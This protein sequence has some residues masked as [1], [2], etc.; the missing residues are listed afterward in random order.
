ME[1]SCRGPRRCESCSDLASDESGLPCAGNARERD[2]ISL[3]NSGC[4]VQ[5]K[6]SALQKHNTENLLQ[7]KQPVSKIQF[8]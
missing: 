4:G 3:N 6:K 5:D 7:H 8:I 1:K 2:G